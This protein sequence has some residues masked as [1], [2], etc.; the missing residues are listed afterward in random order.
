MSNYSLQCQPVDY[1][2]DPLSTR[3][4]LDL[5]LNFFQKIDNASIF[6]SKDAHC[7]LDM[8]FVKNT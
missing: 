5:N 8:L 3:V 4:S 1:S 7:D 2:N 6:F